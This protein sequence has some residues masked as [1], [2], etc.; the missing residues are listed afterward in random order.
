MDIE[1]QFTEIYNAHASKVYSLCLGY[2]AGDED[3]AKE[4]QQETFIKIWK[5][6]KSFEGRS[7]VS[8]WVYRIAANTCL[9]DLRK[10]KPY[11]RIVDIEVA[12]DTVHH[13]ED[14]E[15]QIEKMYRCIGKLTINNKTIILMELEDIP[16]ATI[17]ETTGMAHGTLRTRLNRIRQALLK[18][19]TNGK[20]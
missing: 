16:Q 1:K 17:A 11:V 10:S 3:L 13:I 7:S 4:W 18:C 6:R 14:R 8:T 2:A 9:A 15:S 20:G 19:I 5:H 12:D